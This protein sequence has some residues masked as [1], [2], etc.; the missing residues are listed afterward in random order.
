MRSRQLT[1]DTKADDLRADG[2]ALTR[3][4]IDEVCNTFVNEIGGLYAVAIA[5]MIRTQHPN[6][7]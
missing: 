5:P 3:S 6:A 2:M 1:P 7:P 4:E